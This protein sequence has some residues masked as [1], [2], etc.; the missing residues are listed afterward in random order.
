MLCQ[1]GLVSPEGDGFIS[2]K[3]MEG[4][5]S[6]R[7]SRKSSCHWRVFC[8]ITMTWIS[9]NRNRHDMMFFSFMLELLIMCKHTGQVNQA[10]CNDNYKPL[11]S[12]HYTV[13]CAAPQS[14]SCYCVTAGWVK[15]ASVPLCLE[16]PQSMIATENIL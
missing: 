8:R 2:F 4:E 6:S 12:K 16:S 11:K 1:T 14:F 15:R 3:L 13:N 7:T 9:E 5:T 10:F